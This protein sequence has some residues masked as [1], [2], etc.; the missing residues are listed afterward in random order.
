IEQG[1]TG[2]VL[3]TDGAGDVVW[4]VPAA[5]SV[6]ADGTTITGDGNLTDLS[7][8]TDG[9]TT[10]Q[11][12]DGTIATADIADNNVTPAKIE[13]GTTGQVLTTDGA[14]DVVWAVPA[15]GSVSADGTTIT[16]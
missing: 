8:P 13:Q 4:A 6:S 16:G 1:T 3:T 2:Q 11:I 5:G 10:N 15:A 14:G 9:I 12:L 7:V